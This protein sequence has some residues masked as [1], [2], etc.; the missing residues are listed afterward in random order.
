MVDDL[1]VGQVRGVGYL[2]ANLA[3]LLEEGCFQ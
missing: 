1:H 2:E 3:I